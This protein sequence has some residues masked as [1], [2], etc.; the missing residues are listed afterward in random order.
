MQTLFSQPQTPQIQ[1]NAGTD[2]KFML[3]RRY[4]QDPNK[5]KIQEVV[6]FSYCN[7]QINGSDPAHRGA[8]V[9]LADNPTRQ[10]RTFAEML[11][12]TYEEAEYARLNL[13]FH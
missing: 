8:V 4:K 5:R 11:F 13:F 3:G 6:V 9:A 2:K 7:C 10:F 1:T 12:D